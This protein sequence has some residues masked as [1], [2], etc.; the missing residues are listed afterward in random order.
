MK[1][2]KQQSMKMFVDCDSQWCASSEPT[3]LCFFFL[4]LPLS[5]PFTK[6]NK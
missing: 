4:L 5:F 6:T 3:I 1:Q 2:Q